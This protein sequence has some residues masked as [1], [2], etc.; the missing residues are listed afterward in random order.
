M[1]LAIDGFNP[2]CFDKRGNPGYINDLLQPPLTPVP[3]KTMKMKEYTLLFALIFAGI[4]S[5]QA[6]KAEMPNGEEYNWY[7]S[8]EV[9]NED[10]PLYDEVHEHYRPLRAIRITRRSE[11]SPNP[12]RI[13]RT[14]LRIT[15]SLSRNILPPLDPK[16]APSY[17]RLRQ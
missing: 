5:I 1:L 13:T 2:C 14:P 15:K 4:L 3:P 10:S 6:G 17:K 16:V 8:N 12:I 9:E 11:L 7:M